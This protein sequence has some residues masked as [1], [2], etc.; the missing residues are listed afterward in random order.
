MVNYRIKSKIDKN[1]LPPL[2]H[3]TLLNFK[4]K[5]NIPGLVSGRCMSKMIVRVRFG[6]GFRVRVWVGVGIGVGVRA[7]VGVGVRVR[8][9]VRVGFGFKIR[10]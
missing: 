3:K 1:V 10:G 4:P 2:R 7:R 5:T 6:F 8:V 9:R